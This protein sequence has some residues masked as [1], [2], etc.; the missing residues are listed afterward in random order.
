MFFAQ[1][2]MPIDPF[3]PTLLTEPSHEAH[4]R[5][6]II[7]FFSPGLMRG[8]EPF[9]RLHGLCPTIQA[10]ALLPGL[11]FASRHL[12]DAFLT[13]DFSRSGRIAAAGTLAHALM[14]LVI[15]MLHG[16]FAIQ[17]VKRCASHAVMSGKGSG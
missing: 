16:L 17:E 14:R 2:R 12:V 10:H 4:H 1:G 3:F 11:S 13:T 9:A 15:V 7:A 8:T 6:L 5:A